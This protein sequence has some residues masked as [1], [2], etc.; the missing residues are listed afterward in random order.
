MTPSAYPLFIIGLAIAFY[1]LRVV[2]KALRAKRRSGRAA[3][4]IPR[5]QTGRWNRWLWMP[6]VLVWIVHP[7][8]SALVTPRF[9]WLAPFAIALPLRWLAAGV[10]VLGVILTTFCWK[11]MGKSWRMGIDPSEKTALVVTGPYA[12]VR[13][14]IY[15]LSGLMMLAT[16]AALPSPLMLACGVIHLALL[17]WEARRE[18]RHLAQ[19]HGEGYVRYCLTVGRFVPSIF[20][21]TA[22]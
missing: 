15:A 17:A 7:F 12:W 16:M 20:H 18:E 3:N 4:F 6:V 21:R 11:R 13:H 22:K 2:Q 8:Y 14:P 9:A 5:E 1:W 19:L 10:V